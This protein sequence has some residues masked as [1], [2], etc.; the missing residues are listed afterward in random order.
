M[1][2]HRKLAVQPAGRVNSDINITPLVDVVLVLLIIFMVVTPL[3]EK[4]IGVRVPATEQVEERTEV[5]PDQLVVQGLRVQLDLPGLV[6]G[7]HQLI[8]REVF[9]RDFLGVLVRDAHL[10]VFFQER[11]HH[12]EDDEEHQHHVHQRSDV[13]VRVGAPLVDRVLALLVKVVLRAKAHLLL[14]HTQLHGLRFR[15][16]SILE[17][18]ANVPEGQ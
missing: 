4:D 10:D 3:L 18:L 2:H 8:R 12:H 7:H 13:D 6:D 17:D 5:P 15:V 9:L 11:R 1:R 16:L 14:L